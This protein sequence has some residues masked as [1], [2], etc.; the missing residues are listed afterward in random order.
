MARKRYD[1]DFDFDLNQA[2]NPTL[3][4]TPIRKVTEEERLEKL[5]TILTD[6]ASKEEKVHNLI[7]DY[8]AAIGRL[9]ELSRDTDSIEKVLR[10]DPDTILASLQSR[11]NSLLDDSIKAK[12][13]E[14]DVT[15]SD[16]IGT[17]LA[18]EL[19]SLQIAV[20]ASSSEAIASFE[21]SIDEKVK[22]STER[23]KE[24][25]ENKISV[26]TFVLFRFCMYF[27]GAISFALLAGHDRLREIIGPDEDAKV[28]MVFG[29]AGILFMIG[30]DIWLW[31]KKMI[32]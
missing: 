10:I 27:L 25:D 31:L 32:G 21:K 11:L 12:V 5:I 23:L 4:T 3:E 15:L 29:C 16:R 1:D 8:E 20:S 18:V 22:N 13:Q 7:N 30:R 17:I 26:T 6:I 24:K 19:K 28:F 2:Q 9:K 14:A